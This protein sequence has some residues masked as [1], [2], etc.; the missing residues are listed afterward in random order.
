MPGGL[1][2]SGGAEASLEAGFG[3]PASSTFKRLSSL[4]G[5]RFR[6]AVFSFVLLNH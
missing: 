1:L 5:R 3:L 2:L 4:L 6:P